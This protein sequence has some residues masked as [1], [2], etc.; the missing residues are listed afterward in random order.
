MDHIHKKQKLLLRLEHISQS[1][2]KSGKA[3][4]LIGFGSIAEIGRIDAYSDLDFLVI[5]KKGNK[6]E[7]IENIDWLTSI[8]PVGYYYLFVKDGYKFF[9]EDGIFCDF[10]ILEEDEVKQ[11]PHAEGR[12]IW[13][14]DDFDQS[15][16]LPTHICNYE[17]IDVND[18]SREIGETL[19]SVY[20]G[21]CRFAR[22]E[23]LSA[24]R[25]IQNLA[26]D[27]LLA[28]SNL[29]AKETNYHRDSFQNER[30]YEKRYPSIATYLPKMI[31][32]YEECP[33]SALAI[34]EFVE[35]FYEINHFM[36]TTIVNFA[37]DLIKNR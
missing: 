18:I 13:S 6:S 33:E 26:I 36:K 11:I 25:H 10:G 35:T 31:Q 16:C 21:L 32:G 5:A 15:L 23:K 9:Y 22:G 19:T 1:L 24:T 30:R 14:E 20:V 17:V 28:C 4:A 27:H 12:I 3:R 2:Q 37:N 7:L 34:I 8:A 29:L